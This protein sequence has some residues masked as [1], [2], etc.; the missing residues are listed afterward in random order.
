MEFLTR[1]SYPGCV[2]IYSKMPEYIQ[3]I[4][5]CFPY[6]SFIGYQGVISPDQEYDPYFPKLT[7]VVTT[8]HNVQGTTDLLTD[9]EAVRLSRDLHGRLVLLIAYLE[10][11]ERQMEIWRTLRPRYVMMAKN[12]FSVKIPQGEMILPIYQSKKES[13]I[14]MIVSLDA[15]NILYDEKTLLME[16]GFFQTVTRFLFFITF[17]KQGL[18]L[19]FQNADQLLCTTMNRLQSL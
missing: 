12:I 11:D 8:K 15:K 14:I 18:I 1:Y 16:L 4:A 7:A 17:K 2:C 13:L 6:L 19:V 5:D 10:T 9:A 3:E